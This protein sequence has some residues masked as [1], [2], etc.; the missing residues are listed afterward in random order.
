M[1][2]AEQRETVNMVVSIFE[3]GGLPSPAAYAT[4]TILADGAGV[5]FGVHQAT[6]RSGSLTEVLREYQR[7]GGPVQDTDLQAVRA[8]TAYD[9][10]TLD[11]AA[12]ARGCKAPASDAVLNLLARLRRWGTAPAMQ[13]S[14]E[15][16][17]ERLYWAPAST[18]AAT[19][20]LALPL[21]YL[22]LYDTAIHSGRTRIDALRRTFPEYPPQRGGDERLWT[23]AFIQARDRWLG[24][25]GSA[26]IR[27]TRYRTQALMELV[28]EGRWDLAR[29]F[30][31]RGV[32]IG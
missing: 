14:Q 2:T 32:Q 24:A 20:G 29:P 30:T 16:V 26:L 12:R 27:S 19:I 25:S 31:V 10:E 23:A 5:S 18:Y 6:A 7:R 15:L 22:V 21:S 11:A 4:A 8:S 17:F 28:H 13:L 1:L 9:C 3:N